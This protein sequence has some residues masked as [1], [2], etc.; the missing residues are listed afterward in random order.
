M[1]DRLPVNYESVLLVNHDEGDYVLCGY[2]HDGDWYT[3][4]GGSELIGVSHWQPLPEPPDT[5]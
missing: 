5:P 3:V 1:K 4:T 2:C